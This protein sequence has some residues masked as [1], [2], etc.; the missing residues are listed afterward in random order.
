MNGDV[1]L[2]QPST[3][4]GIVRLVVLAIAT[5]SFVTIFTLAV[6]LVLNIKPDTVILTA[7]VSLAGQL[8]GALTG[9]LINTRSQ[10]T[11]TPPEPPQP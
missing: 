7:F 4:P 3:K 1:D 10:K 2:T 5:G 8:T 9:L 6:L 11:E